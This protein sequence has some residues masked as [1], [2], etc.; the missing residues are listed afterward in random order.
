MK[1]NMKVTKRDVGWLVLGFVTGGVL[2]GSVTPIPKRVGTAPILDAVTVSSKLAS[3]TS[4]EVPAPALHIALP[5]IRERPIQDK[6]WYA[7]M[8]RSFDLIDTHSRDQ[9]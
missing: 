1:G 4:Q 3:L 2:I 8:P 9:N 6:T 5:M 7:P